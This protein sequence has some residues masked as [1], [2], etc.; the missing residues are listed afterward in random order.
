MAAAVHAGA[1]VWVRL[2]K[3]E[4]NWRS[5][6]VVEDASSTRVQLDGETTVVELQAL[7][8]LELQ[9]AEEAEVRQPARHS[10]ESPRGDGQ[11]GHGVLTSLRWSLAVMGA[12]SRGVACSSAHAGA[13]R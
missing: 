13:L 4:G 11:Q 3:E 1:A 6:R 5:A 10:N 2:A 9:N 8:G 12:G 7:G